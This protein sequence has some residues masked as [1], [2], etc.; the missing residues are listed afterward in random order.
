LA[1][2]ILAL[3]AIA[4]AQCSTDD[5]DMNGVPD[6][7]PAG[8][9]YIEGTAA[10]ET[11]RGTN[12]ADC[13]F[14]LGGADTIIGRNG[15]DYICA[16]DGDDDVT[17][18]GGD[19]QI[20]GEGG[21]DTIVGSPGNDF[22]DG[23]D[24]ADTLDGSAGDDTIN[25]GAGN[26]VINGG[27]GADAL[28]GQDGDDTL[29]GSG[30]NDALSG[31]NG[32][33][34]LD[35][36][37]GA[38]TCVEEVPGTS[39]RLTNCDAVTYAAV[40]GLEV[41]RGEH[42][43]TVT[44]DTTTE[45]GAVA[46]RLWRRE[47]NGALTWVG[48][49]AA[50]PDGSPHGAR[51]F[52][53]DE[54]APSVG[55][56]EYII[57]ERTVSG[58]SV[59]YGPFVRSSALA[60]VGDRLLRSTTTQDRVPHQV[61][62]WRL[63]RPAL[64]PAI[65]SFGRKAAEMPTGAVLEV[66]QPG[67]IEVDATVIAQALQTSSD[68][69]ADLIRS[70]GLHLRLRGE[71][72]AWHSVDDG[73][74]IR[75][76]AP[77]VSSPFSSRHR[78]LLSVEDG[79]TMETRALIQGAGVEP[80]TFV[81]TK[82]FEENVFAGPSGGP[83]PRQD[84]FF[85]HALS[86]EAR[87][88]IPVSLPALS[89]SAAEGLRVYV[90][91]A[92]EHPEQPHRVEL[93]W[94][95]QS[96]GV[97]DLLGRTRHTIT[98]PL[99]G[100]P[101]GLENELVVQQHVA[102]E[103]PPVL[104]ADAVEVDYVRDAAADARAFQFGGAE[105][106]EHTVTGLTSETVDVYDI[107][108]PRSP[109]HYGEMPPDET[110]RLSFAVAGSD[111]RFLIAAPQSV[112]VPLEVT[113]HFSSSLRSR[114]HAVDY[115]IIAASH[116]LADAHALADL[117]EADGYRVLLVDIDDV[118]WAFTDG[119]PDPLAIR[120]FLS[121]ASQEWETAPRFAT[122]VGKGNLDYR[123]LMGLG[124]N[125]LPPALAPTDGGL[126]PSDSM[127]GD[128]V[129]EDGAPEIA[130]GRLPITTGE[131]LS[132]IIAAIESFEEGH[133]SMNA[134]FAADDSER[135]EF[136]AAMRLLTGWTT[137]ERAQE[138]DLNAETLESARERLLSMWQGPLSWVSYLGHAG[139]D[140]LAT[141]GLL[142]SADVPALAQMQSTPV[143]LGWTCNMVRFDIPGF[144]SLGEQLVTEGTSA[145]VFSA[146]G[147]SN[148]V[149]TDALRT[150]FTQAVFASDAETIGEAM[151]RAHQAASDAPVPL[152]RVYM[153]LGDPALRLRAPK[154]QS[155]PDPVP[156]PEIDTPASGDLGD[157]GGAPR[158]GDQVPSSGSGCE[159]A[160]RG[161]RPGPLGPW[162]IAAGLTPLFRRRRALRQ[163][164]SHLH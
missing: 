90:H 95:G 81:E 140:R 71:S 41:L 56:V 144:F 16:G 29:E 157:S 120:D 77:E 131:E 65:S 116:L 161:D 46:F 114:D 11:L 40:R 53:R 84:L 68:G 159:I 150:A 147:W 112:S 8:T 55:L 125:W 1:V 13:I 110:G 79:V 164:R 83:D 57:E 26:D 20:F 4:G 18:G 6:V 39:E 25:G 19:D 143:V 48:E 148:H 37:G 34:T 106:G 111:L 117:R 78:Y 44:W 156:V 33:D 149:D 133:E 134:L 12:G 31:G 54:S 51:Y 108:D 30:G 153:F 28:S 98:V 92:T 23:G 69:V 132:R 126:F 104:Y 103:A 85:W 70:G 135:D 14:G 89:D 21:N 7:C 52:L 3:P 17:G 151:I 42:G 160:P 67:V 130:I 139:L 88:V 109:K 50:A 35:G 38:N 43:L 94:N 101:A 64:S 99:E 146:T 5:L 76:V 32:I 162:L 15:A 107:T 96:L 22:I 119:E 27:A 60:G 115:V 137:S 66:N 82:R 121:F 158:V 10:G 100:L 61:V 127:L 80:H 152:H 2:A 129:G 138:I 47:G 73:A 49:I 102:G 45:V 105:E 154:A 63:A 163:R 86:S 123:D 87:A 75:F 141:E 136:A 124:G 122:L 97:F 93:H 58:G 145:G 72:I 142:T 155:D 74:A 128:V 59:Q 62:F 9:N 91:G 24:G 118:Y 113:P 36:G